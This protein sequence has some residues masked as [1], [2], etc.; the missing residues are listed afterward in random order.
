L[1]Y[2]K[3]DGVTKQTAPAIEKHYLDSLAALDQIFSE[4]P[5]LFGDRPCEADYGLFGPFFRH[6]FCDPT[7][8]SLMRERAPHVLNWVTRL[9]KTR[10]ED[11]A[12]T[13]PAPAVPDD[14]SYFFN[15]ICA[16]YLPYLAANAEAVARGEQQVRY[17]AQGVDW[18]IPS[19]PYRAQCLNDLKQ[20]FTELSDDVQA[21]VADRLTP[22]A[23]AL[24][25]APATEVKQ[26]AGRLGR[27]WRAA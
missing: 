15:M 27:L 19:A 4:R 11:L 9:W 26:A 10:A 23:L 22:A 6:F 8:G 25:R 18:E 3:Q 12:H 14:L 16:D 21:A 5:F 2:L 13:A 1:V 24:L 17:H 20:K 7:S